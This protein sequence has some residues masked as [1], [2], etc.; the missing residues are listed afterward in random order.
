MNKIYLWG[1]IVTVAMLAFTYVSV[2][3]SKG[4]FNGD[5]VNMLAVG[6]AVALVIITVFVVIKY[7]RQMQVDTA[8]GELVDTSWDGI[9]E[10]YNP[11][12][13]GWAILYL[14]TMVWGM[15]Y[16]VA[17]YPV[18]SYSQIGEYNEDVVVHN[19]KFAKDFDEKMKSYTDEEKAQYMVDM[20]ESVFLAECKVCHGLSADGI[21]GKA[22]DLNVR[23]GVVSVK[24]VILN[25]SNNSLM[26]SENAMPN[27]DGIM[28]ANKDYAAITDAEIDAVSAYVA[29]GMSGEGSD[30]FAGACAACHGVD[31]KG[32]EYVA[33]NIATYDTA[34]ITNVLNHGKKGYIGT[35][36][37]F[38]RL[39]STQ[40]EAVSAYIISL[41]KGE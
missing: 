10:Y 36:P 3:G 18:N 5:I 34:L 22:A 6:G 41:S 19:T 14:A 23:L 12:P 40:K 38:D 37:A 11:I 28:N 29:N 2:I 35:M 27:R 21:D 8:D 17:G 4:G 32:M 16:F 31:G 25:G 20:G 39:N 13:T 1:I 24:D 9:G 26:G 30:V 33:P 15:W 7:V